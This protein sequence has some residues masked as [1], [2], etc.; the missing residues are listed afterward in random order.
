MF[1][2]KTPTDGCSSALYSYTNIRG[3]LSPL[4][5]VHNPRAALSCADWGSSRYGEAILA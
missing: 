3:L 1:S 4:P 5:D 2:A